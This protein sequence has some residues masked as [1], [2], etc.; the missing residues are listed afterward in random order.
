MIDIPELK[1]ISQ[2]FIN[3]DMTRIEIPELK[4]IEN[5]FKM[6]PEYELPDMPIYEGGPTKGIATDVA[7][8]AREEQGVQQKYTAS[9]IINYL[10]AVTGA[11]DYSD[12]ADRLQYLTP[13]GEEMI[14]NTGWT[15]EE[16]I[17]EINSL[18]G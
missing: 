4:G 3:P 15:V 5:M 10:M 6:K 17:E 16:L 13:E 8:K 14:K 1:G 9:D 2:E 12:L 11:Q 7:R 18:K